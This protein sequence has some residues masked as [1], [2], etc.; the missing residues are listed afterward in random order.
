M[1]SSTWPGCSAP[2]GGRGDLPT[3]AH[4][5]SGDQHL[6]GAGRAGF[7]PRE[8]EEGGGWGRRGVPGALRAARAQMAPGEAAGAIFVVGSDALGLNARIPLALYHGSA[9]SSVPLPFSHRRQAAEAAAGSGQGAM[10]GCAA[11]LPTRSSS[12]RSWQGFTGT[13]AARLGAWGP[14][15]APGRASCVPE[16]T[17]VTSGTPLSH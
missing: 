10:G 14:A 4:C 16:I 1:S 2:R 3:S 13:G 12:R 7:C 15:G 8:E 6:Q 9:G 17:P 5:P 11:A